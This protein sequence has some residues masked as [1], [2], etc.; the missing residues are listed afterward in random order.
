DGLVGTLAADLKALRLPIDLIVVSDHGMETVQGNW[1]D[2]DK[3]TDLSQF[4]TIGSLI[5][6]PSEEAAAHAYQQLNGASD[7]FFVSR[8]ADVPAYLHFNENAREGDP[9]VIPTGPYMIRAHASETPEIL[10]PKVK[11][12]HGYDPSVMKSMRAIFYAAGPDIR[13]GAEIQP[14][15]NIDVYPLIAEILGL[16]IGHIDGDLSVLRPILRAAQSSKFSLAAA[17]A[18]N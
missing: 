13:P 18:P 16:R 3:F 5:Y 4:V 1:I 15:E 6:P 14:F 17:P 10:Q 8:R 12:E 9:V 11:G 7:K 2:L